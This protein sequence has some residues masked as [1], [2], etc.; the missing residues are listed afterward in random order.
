MRGRTL[1]LYWLGWG[2]ITLAVTLTLDG[3]GG[4]TV[5]GV[6]LLFN[7]LAESMNSPL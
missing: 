4:L 3:A 7:A 2:C 6:G 1:L 5:V